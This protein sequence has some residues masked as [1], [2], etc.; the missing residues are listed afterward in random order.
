MNK[1]VSDYLSSYYEIFILSKINTL[2]KVPSAFNVDIKQLNKHDALFS[3]LVVIDIYRN[4]HYQS[5]SDEDDAICEELETLIRDAM[6]APVKVPLKGR[7]KLYYDLLRLQRLLDELSTE[8]HSDEITYFIKE[9]VRCTPHTAMHYELLIKSEHLKV[10][11]NRLK[12]LIARL[13]TADFDG[14]S[15]YAVKD[16]ILSACAHMDEIGQEEPIEIPDD[17]Y[18][19]M[20]QW[21]LKSFDNQ[22]PATLY[23]PQKMYRNMPYN[24]MDK[25][26]WLFAHRGQ[27]K[28][29]NGDVYWR[30]SP[31]YTQLEASVEFAFSN[32]PPIIIRSDDFATLPAP[33]TWSLTTIPTLPASHIPPNNAFKTYYNEV[34]ADFCA[35]VEASDEERT[36]G[37]LSHIYTQA[38]KIRVM[39]EWMLNGINNVSLSGFIML[40]SLEEVPGV[41]IDSAYSPYVMYRKL[42]DYLAYVVCVDDQEEKEKVMSAIKLCTIIVN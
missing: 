19:F 7:C 4:K 12:Q 6:I 42:I 37:Y 16:I 30:K 14:D 18:E 10:Y 13:E 26:G 39:S 2:E 32:Y 15:E 1:V 25:D 20:I 23:P 27:M 3:L 9:M 29:M 35:C 21:R 36:D 17:R 34:V 41:F 31:I 8:I 28:Y 24:K 40:A 22:S 11:Y 33:K 38:S 5:I